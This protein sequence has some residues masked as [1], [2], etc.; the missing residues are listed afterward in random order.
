M[1]FFI[2]HY[3]LPGN[4]SFLTNKTNITWR[5]I[6]WNHVSVI[7][8]GFSLPSTTTQILISTSLP[9]TPP[10]LRNSHITSRPNRQTAIRLGLSLPFFLQKKLNT[11]LS[12]TIR[13][14]RISPWSLKHFDDALLFLFLWIC[15]IF[16]RI[17]VAH[18]LTSYVISLPYC[19]VLKSI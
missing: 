1:K 4:S 13:P 9:P 5:N 16:L 3:M 17:L 15:V 14:I 6:W 18:C 2:W 10:S 12:E 11:P 19:F 7:S 8:Q